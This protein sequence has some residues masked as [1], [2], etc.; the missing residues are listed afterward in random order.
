MLTDGIGVIIAVF[1]LIC[2]LYASRAT[3][4][5]ATFIWATL[6][7]AASNFSVMVRPSNMVLVVAWL[8]GRISLL[9]LRQ[10]RALVWLGCAAAW[11][12]TA[13]CIWAAQGLRNPQLGSLLESHLNWG[14]AFLKHAAI[15]NSDRAEPLFFPNP[16][17]I[18]PLSGWAWYLQHPYSGAAT[19]AGHIVGAF[20]FE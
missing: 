3:S 9:F 4:G 7:A 2:L 15:V 20:N 5:R 12:T 17:C 1:T 8:C 14:I 10:R 11:A 19:L 13:A 18:D 16:W 6:G